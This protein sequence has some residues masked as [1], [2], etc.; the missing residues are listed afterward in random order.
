MKGFY[1]F[2]QE[3]NGIEVTF[4]SKPG[5]DTINA[6]R[7]A[8]YRWHKVKKLWYAKQTPERLRIAESIAAGEPAPAK[9]EEVLPAI[10]RINLENLGK[11]GRKHGAD[12]AQAIREELKTRGVK[13]VTV[14]KSASGYTDSIT[15][16]IKATPADFVS[17]EEGALRY[18]RGLFSIDLDRGLWFNGK[19]LYASEY[20]TMTEEEKY[21]AHRAY[22]AHCINRLES[23]NHHHIERKNYF[24]L[25][26]AFY[27]KVR[28]AFLIANQWNY[29]N[30][31]P[32]TDYF[33]IGYYL[34]IDIKKS[35][36]FEPRQ[37]MTDAD[38]AAYDQEQR[39]ER[40]KEEAALKAYEEKRK[41]DEAAAAKYNAWRVA[42]IDEILQNVTIEDLDE[43]NALYIT[44]LA[45][46]IGKE[47]TLAE[48]RETI[49][50]H[51]TGSQDAEITRKASFTSLS[52]YD[53]FCKL[54]LEDF[55]FLAGKGGTGT[56][57]TRIKDTAQ[58]Y[59][60]TTDQR[61]SVK[62][63]NCDCIGVYYKNVLQL[64]I[65]PEGHD[66]SRYVY[67][68]TNESRISNAAETLKDQEQQSETKPAF[69]FPEPVEKQADALSIGEPITIY[70]CDG[71]IL[72]NI[73]AGSGIVTGFYMGEYAQYKNV[74]WIELLNA[75]G[76]TQKIHIRDGNEALVYKGI[77]NKL[78]E[79]VTQ[80][81]LSATM[82]ELLN[83]NELFPNTYN[84]YLT[85]GETPII[86][87]CYR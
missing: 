53:N 68:P 43:N 54:F 67:E 25:T 33:D 58:F 32:M 35:A 22:I 66:Y 18:P 20:E 59:R 27:N 5:Q 3:L 2:N 55:D 60:M 64:V 65:N 71:W 69:Y 29:D 21:A 15:L 16:T 12:L 37:T 57:D 1:T 76:K 61:E 52:A 11:T 75:K 44:N 49:A 56:Q 41:A 72:N 19:Y 46:G 8:G 63:Y 51:E 34:H 38:R 74:L 80:R 86:D 70:Q 7:A 79:E 30:S 82:T 78:P 42:A 84:Y 87:T 81:R 48:L 40:E 50:T 24:E 39:E 83:Y 13:G 14:R 17:I 45:G 6:L 31:D 85:Q 4:E 47:A 10:E 36:D 9:A 62:F 73:F 77:K 23:V 28:A 26:T